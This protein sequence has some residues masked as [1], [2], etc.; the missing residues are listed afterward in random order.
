MNH[1][2]GL[3]ASFPEQADRVDYGVHACQMRFPNSGLLRGREIHSHV[4]RAWQS[5]PD[6]RGC[7]HRAHQLVSRIEKGESEA[8]THEP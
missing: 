7:A 3:P 8:M 4:S 1:I 5:F 2:E 6:R